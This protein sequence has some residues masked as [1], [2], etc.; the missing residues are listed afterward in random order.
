MPEAEGAGV[1]LGL[2]R[3][4][5]QQARLAGSVEAH[6]HDALAALDLERNVAKNERSAITL[7]QPRRSQHDATAVRGLR[8]GDLHL[9]LALGRGDLLCLHPVAALELRFAGLPP[10]APL[11]PH[12][13]PNHPHPL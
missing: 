10:L 2:A 4:D 6:D 9:A 11:S 12:A 5:A 3:Q 8:K 1:R 7:A 13:L